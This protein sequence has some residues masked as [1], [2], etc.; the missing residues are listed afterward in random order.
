MV[1][2]NENH[3]NFKLNLKKAL[4]STTA[5][6]IA[7]IIN[8]KSLLSRFV[9]LVLCVVSSTICIILIV[10]S[11]GAYF[12]Y[13]VL[14]KISYESLETVPFPIVTF[15]SQN[16][17]TT[18]QARDFFNNFINL[19]STQ[20]IMNAYNLTISRNQTFEFDI[21][22]YDLAGEG[23]TNL[24]DLMKY[25]KLN[26]LT[27]K[28]IESLSYSLDESMI[29]CKFNKISCLNRSDLFL[30]EV[31]SLYGVCFQ[32]NPNKSLVM[33]SSGSLNS[34][35]VEL[36]VGYKNTMNILNNDK[37]DGVYLFINEEL[38]SPRKMDIIEIPLGYSTSIRM[39]RSR[40]NKLPKPFSN[41]IV[42][43]T[44][45]DAS[46]SFL[47]KY[48]VKEQKKQYRKDDCE[49]LQT[50]NYI[51]IKC[52]CSLNFIENINQIKFCKSRQEAVCNR[53]YSE[54]LV[55]LPPKELSES[56]G[57]CPIVCTQYKYEFKRS[58]A[59]FPSKAYEELLKKDEKILKKF[60]Y[61][62]SEVNN[63]NLKDSIVAF[64]VYFET[65]LLERIDEIPV[66]TEYSLISSNLTF[67]F[68]VEITWNL[69]T[70]KI[71]KGI[72]GILG[73]FMG[74]SFLTLFELVDFT[75]RIIFII[76]RK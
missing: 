26:L 62:I 40:S 37:T 9:W 5:H 58:M 67:P 49:Y 11:I 1:R 12:S 46:T 73:L 7:N 23:V 35:Y 6:G 61:N 55:T 30:V 3:N 65:L 53:F 70:E 41:C 14:T 15:C 32:F 4:T 8:K 45:Q 34:F 57:D 69:K 72:G 31:S 17:L 52:N 51:N 59:S 28:E 56:A 74:I 43:E 25:R 21:K 39:K 24:Y 22:N 19:N 2:N 20:Q 68:F 18:D 54:E 63:Q 10:K 71:S 47:F 27:K 13:S 16:G 76:F 33:S 75:I 38:V 50:Q 66:M 42:N 29:K 44:D 48:I 60:N 36:Y 64:K